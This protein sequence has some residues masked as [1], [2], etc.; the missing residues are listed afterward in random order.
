MKFGY[1]CK[2]HSTRNLV[3]IAHAN[4][5]VNAIKKKKIIIENLVRGW[6]KKKKLT[7]TYVS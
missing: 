3:I 6:F 5:K 7:K 1:I 4:E 2:W